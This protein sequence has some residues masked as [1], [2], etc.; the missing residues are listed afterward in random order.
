MNN[1]DELLERELDLAVERLRRVVRIRQ[2]KKPYSTTDSHKYTI[3][4]KGKVYRIK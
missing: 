3:S 1:R 4:P 2:G